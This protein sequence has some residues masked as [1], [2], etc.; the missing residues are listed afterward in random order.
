MRTLFPII[1][2][3]LSGLMVSCMK[4]KPESFPEELV[5]NPELAIPLGV[6]RFGLNDESGFDTTQFQLDTLT[7]QPEW[8]GKVEVVMTGGVE[9]DLSALG[10]SIENINRVLFRVG[11]SN[12]FPNEVW[13]QA[14]FTDALS[15]PIDSMF[16]DGPI[17]LPAATP[18]GDGETTR[19]VVHRKD[20]IFENDRIGP[21]EEA[22]EIM[23]RAVIHD[24]EPDT[25]LIPFY[26]GYYIEMELGVMADLTFEF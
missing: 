22:T 12:G 1:L 19:P 18:I 21:L 8:V 11:L 15:N 26:P 3:L 23:F 13:A 5:W 16:S 24:P 14:Y 10:T 20:V 17:L 7:G 2:V 9:F 4:D 6:D 25:T